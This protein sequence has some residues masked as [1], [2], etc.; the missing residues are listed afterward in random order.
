[1]G[2]TEK[3]GRPV[4]APAGAIKFDISDLNLF[5]GDFQALKSVG[6]RLPER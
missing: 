1:M 4:Q 3:A 2:Q 5:Y 6:L